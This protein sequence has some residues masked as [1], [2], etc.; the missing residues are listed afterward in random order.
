MYGDHVV[1]DLF[2]IFESYVALTANRRGEVAKLRGF[3]FVC[4]VSVI[5]PVPY[6]DSLIYPDS[7]MLSLI[8]NLTSHGCDVVTEKI[9]LPRRRILHG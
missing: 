6:V 1:G 4:R 9:A 3:H 7:Y 8:V 2:S 5:F